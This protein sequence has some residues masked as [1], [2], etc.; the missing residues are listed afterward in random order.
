MGGAHT[1]RE[2]C[3]AEHLEEWSN[4]K[5]WELGSTPLAPIY[6]IEKEKQ[7]SF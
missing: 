7:D 4:Q 2:A 6:C 3:S 5:V 1:L